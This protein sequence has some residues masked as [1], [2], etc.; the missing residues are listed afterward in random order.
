M[1]DEPILVEAFRYA[2]LLLV[3]LADPRALAAATEEPD[4]RPA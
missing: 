4:R 2:D 1:L 3:H